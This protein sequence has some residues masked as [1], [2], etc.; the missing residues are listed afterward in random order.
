MNQTEKQ[1]EQEMI[2]E[3]ERQ[4]REIIVEVQA[5]NAGELIQF[6]KTRHPSENFVIIRDIITDMQKKN[7][8][9]DEMLKI[10]FKEINEKAKI[11][12]DNDHKHA[13]ILDL[14]SA[15]NQLYNHLSNMIV[16]IHKELQELKS[17]IRQE[18]PSIEEVK[19]LLNPDNY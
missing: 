13:T 1:K 6:L 2:A 19:E 16:Q 17:E 11:S 12:W 14:N 5:K 18:K 3:Q 9:N 8:R 15:I 4:R 7:I 10:E